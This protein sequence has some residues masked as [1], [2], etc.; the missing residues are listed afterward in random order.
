[1]PRIKEECEG[2]LYFVNGFS[3][4]S[5]LFFHGS[6]LH[7][8]LPADLFYLWT[9]VCCFKIWASKK[10]TKRTPGR[11]LFQIASTES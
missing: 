3:S 7:I 5:S 1:M 11:N 6:S 2:I 9:S 10:T 8:H 4:R